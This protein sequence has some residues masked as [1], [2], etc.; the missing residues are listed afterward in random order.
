M[1]CIAV[2]Y[3]YNRVNNLAVRLDFL[4]TSKV[5][6]YKYGLWFVVF[7]IL[8][9]ALSMAY[10]FHL[11]ERYVT[12]EVLCVLRVYVYLSVSVSIFL[13]FSMLTASVFIYVC[14]V[15]VIFQ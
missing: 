14:V 2:L 9:V 8:M 15:L 10:S 11:A 4:D 6:F 13:G 5:A 12:I 1:I 7:V 3:T